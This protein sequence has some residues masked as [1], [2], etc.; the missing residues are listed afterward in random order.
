MYFKQISWLMCM[1]GLIESEW[2]RTEEVRYKKKRAIS[3][4]G[5]LFGGGGTQEYG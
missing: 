1:Q 2:R 3:R 5:S 4:N